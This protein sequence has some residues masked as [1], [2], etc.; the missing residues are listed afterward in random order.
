MGKE[1]KGDRVLGVNA[2]GAR[3][4]RAQQDR[5]RILAFSAK[6]K[7]ITAPQIQEELEMTKAVVEHS[8]R[9]LVKC[10]C[11]RRERINASKVKY[12]RTE[13]EY[14]PTVIDT[15][16]AEPKKRPYVR[17]VPYVKPPKEALEDKRVV[18]KVD[19]YTTQYFLSRRAAPK[20]YT[21]KNKARASMFSGIQSGMGMF[22]AL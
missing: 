18:I 4:M 14:I 3:L 15:A 7:F 5:L 12:A 9:V 20:E 6:H 10:G 2:K 19:A 13:V 21:S 16:P 17:K 22:N 1:A 11:L 8:L